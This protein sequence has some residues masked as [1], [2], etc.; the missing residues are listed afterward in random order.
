MPLS[1]VTGIFGMN[2]RQINGSG[3]NIWVCFATLVPVIFVTMLVFWVVKL[4]GNRIRSKESARKE[5]SY[6]SEV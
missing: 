5:L 6:H 4:N 3:L 2:I 1:F